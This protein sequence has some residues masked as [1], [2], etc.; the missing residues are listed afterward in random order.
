MNPSTFGNIDDLVDIIDRHYKLAAEIR[1]LLH[2]G[3]AGPNPSQLERC[4]AL[5]REIAGLP[6]KEKVGP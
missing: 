1:F 6:A 5:L 4:D 3:G 2:N